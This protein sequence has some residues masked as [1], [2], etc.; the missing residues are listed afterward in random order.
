[1]QVAQIEGLRPSRPSRW[2]AF[3]EAAVGCLQKRQIQKKLL[4]RKSQARTSR[5]RTLELGIFAALEFGIG[6]FSTIP[7]ARRGKGY[8]KV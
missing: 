7:H 3:F 8:C 2:G 4:I 6:S 5:F 1:M